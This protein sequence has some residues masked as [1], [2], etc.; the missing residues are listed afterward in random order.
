MHPRA[1]GPDH[2]AGD[3]VRPMKALMLLAYLALGIAWWWVGPHTGY[4][5]ALMSEL[6]RQ[7]LTTFSNQTVMW[8]LTLWFE[9]ALGWYA[10]TLI[11]Q[12]VRGKRRFRWGASAE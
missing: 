12:V 5:V 2:A 4:A 6:D 7:S 1:S 10:V 8:A 11:W 3:R 9:G